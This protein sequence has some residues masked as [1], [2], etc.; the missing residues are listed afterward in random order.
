MAP[1]A[2]GLAISTRRPRRALKGSWLDPSSYDAGKKMWPAS[3]RW[4]ANSVGGSLTSREDSS[5]NRGRRGFVHLMK[6][7]VVLA[8]V[9]SQAVKTKIA[10]VI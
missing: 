5:G 9:L 2:T 6:M 1:A 4:K 7:V 3:N 8:C 10:N